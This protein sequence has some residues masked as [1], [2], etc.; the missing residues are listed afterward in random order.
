MS[1][2]IKITEVEDVCFNNDGKVPYLAMSKPASP[3][4]VEM[5]LNQP[6]DTSDGRSEWR[7]FRL[8]NGDLILG[9]YPQGNTY[10]ATEHESSF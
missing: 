6:T 2:D 5:V 3:E 1:K 10:F 8:P 4:L 7:W 9:V